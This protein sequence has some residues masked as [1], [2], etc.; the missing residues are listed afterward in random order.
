MDTRIYSYHYCCTCHSI[1]DAMGVSYFFIEWKRR[2]VAIPACD[3]IIISG[4]DLVT[5]P[6]DQRQDHS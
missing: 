4:S 6:V 3:G 1:P 2:L 5:V